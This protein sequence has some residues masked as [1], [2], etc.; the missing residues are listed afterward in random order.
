M[1]FSFKKFLYTWTFWIIFSYLLNYILQNFIDNN[2]E[3]STEITSLSVANII[4]IFILFNIN[5]CLLS[6]RIDF[7]NIDFK[8]LNFLF[9][10]ATILHASSLGSSSF[11]EEEHQTWYF[12]WATF[13]VFIFIYY[14]KKTFN[15]FYYKNHFIT[16]T[17]VTGKILFLLIA[18]RLLRKLNSTGN[19]YAHQ[20]DINGWLKAL[21]QQS[22]F[23]MTFILL[24]G[25]F[26]INY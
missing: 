26:F 11:I 23:Y 20:P 10:L 18:H 3:E 2:N 16:T 6:I 25:N 8:N 4:M 1:K 19:K 22:N 17:N 12:Y 13:I 9:L 14:I 7:V 21:N 5:S 24:M 15:Y